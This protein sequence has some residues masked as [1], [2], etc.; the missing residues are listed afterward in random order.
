MLCIVIGILI[1]SIWG[2]VFGNRSAWVF[3]M[4]LGW[5]VAIA[6]PM[7]T[8]IKHKTYTIENLQDNSTLSGNFLL[9][10]G[11]VNGSMKYALYV[12]EKSM[13]K[14]M[15]L[16]VED[17]KIKYSTNKPTLHHYEDDYL[18][19]FQNWWAFDFISGG[20][21]NYIIEVPKGTIQN[22]YTLDAQ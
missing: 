4:L 14:L 20:T 5:V 18:R 6:L 1:G 2:W 7:K 15:L 13:F 8:N 10:C 22:N 12:K 21:S 9:G 17:C 11:N 16:D 3:G 19:L